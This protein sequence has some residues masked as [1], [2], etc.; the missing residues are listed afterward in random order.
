[1][2]SGKYEYGNMYIENS[3]IA[4]IDSIWQILYTDSVYSGIYVRLRIKRNGTTYLV[5]DKNKNSLKTEIRVIG[6]T[7]SFN[8]ELHNKVRHRRIF[9]GK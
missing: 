9:G 7:V 5:P 1:M 2:H 4:E 6:E 3:E 8:G